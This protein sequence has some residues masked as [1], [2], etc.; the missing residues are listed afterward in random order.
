MLFLFNL[1]KKKVEIEQS[2]WYDETWLK[3]LEY[4]II[5]GNGDFLW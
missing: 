2:T 5:M 4:G 1:Y 3:S